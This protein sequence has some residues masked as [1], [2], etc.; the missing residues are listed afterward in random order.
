MPR[1]NEFDQP[2]GDALPHWSPR[3]RPQHTTLQ[4]QFCRLEPLDAK[5]HA[6]DLFSALSLAPDDRDWTYLAVEKFGSFEA[7]LAYLEAMQISQDPLFFA[8]IDG[9]T[10][11]A[12]GYV[13]LMR[14]DSASGVVEVGNINCSA[15][16]QR[17]V[18][19]T[20]VQYLLMKYI[21]ENLGYRRLEWKCDSFN[22]PSRRAALR[23]GFCFE[24][25]FRR[26]MVYKGRSRDTAWFSITDDGWPVIKASLETW[27][28]S[29]NFEPDGM[30]RVSLADIRQRL[31]ASMPA[32]RPSVQQ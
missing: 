32:G 2:I 24:G 16:L 18:A 13:T 22:A 14:I 26:A 12:V 29:D 3:S 23:L 11:N 4:G 31:V 6:A 5:H 27:M 25:I 1:L 21:F 19:A 17:T 15:V 7:A 8:V 28:S 9:Q 20:E 30:Q 10:Q